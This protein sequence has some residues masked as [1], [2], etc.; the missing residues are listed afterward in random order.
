M[1]TGKTPTNQRQ[2]VVDDFQNDDSVRLLV[3][4]IIAGGVGINLTA[5]RHIVFNDLDWVP[6]NHWQAEDRAYRIGQQHTVNVYYFVAKGTLDEFVAEVLKAKTQI[7]EA[8]VEGKS[9]AVDGAATT[10]VLTELRNLVE[11]L[12]TS[13]GDIVGQLLTQAG[14]LYQQ[15]QPDVP[16]SQK[17]PAVQTTITPAALTALAMSLQREASV[18]YRMANSKGD[19]FYTLEVDGSDITCSCRGFEYRGQ[20]KHSRA[21]KDAVA[22]GDVPTEFEKV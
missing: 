4:N 20:C 7:I 6:A 17:R 11:S 21:L 18:R 10:D 12:D 3:C 22:K 14:D 19:D 15:Q 9:I 5:A 1:L 2:G 8:V 16:V 13:D